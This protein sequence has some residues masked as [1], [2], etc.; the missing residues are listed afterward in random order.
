MTHN[1]HQVALTLVPGVGSI[2]IRQ[3]ISYCGSADDVF[4]SPLGRL[5]K[6]PGIGEVTARSIHKPDVL[7]AAER[8]LKQLEKR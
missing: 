7:I 4:R 1:L 8:V 3:L 2:L 6:I 5:L